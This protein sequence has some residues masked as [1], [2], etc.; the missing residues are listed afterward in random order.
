M[1]FRSQGEQLASGGR[2]GRLKIWNARTGTETLSVESGTW[3]TSLAFH[4][5]GSQLAVSTIDQTI[6]LYKLE[7]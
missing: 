7:K 3:I 6:L 1:L 5:D 4:P 2:D